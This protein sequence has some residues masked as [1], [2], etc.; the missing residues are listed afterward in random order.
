LIDFE[1]KSDATM[2][3]CYARGMDMAPHSDPAEL[4]TLTLLKAE[5]PHG[6]AIGCGVG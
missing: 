2:R 5:L 6:S 4:V 1:Q 3:G